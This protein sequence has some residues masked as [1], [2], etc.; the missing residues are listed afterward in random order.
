MRI[1]RD[2]EERVWKYC[3]NQKGDTSPPYDSN[4]EFL[5]VVAQLAS[6]PEVRAVAT[7]NFDTLLENAISS[8]GAKV[9]Y[10][11]HGQVTS[12]KGRGV[13][14]QALAREEKKNAEVLPIFHI[15]GLLSPVHALL[16]NHNEAV[17]LS[18][19]EYF[20]KNADPLSWETSTSLHLLRNY[21]SL[22]LGT[23]LKDWNMMRLLH[24]ALSGRNDVHSYAIQCLREVEPPAD[25][26]ENCIQDF[27]RVAMRFQASLLDTVGVKLIIAGDEFKDIPTTVADHIFRPLKNKSEVK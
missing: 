17:V 22:W 16:H 18:Y 26:P 12:F 5:K 23:S 13:S 8:Y 3:Q 2:V 25:V 19:D 7:F 6:L 24:S 11:Y 4:L 14:D 21:C 15:H 20:D 10:A 27:R 9:P 1:N